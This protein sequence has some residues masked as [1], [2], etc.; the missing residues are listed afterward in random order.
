MVFC[1][2]YAPAPL[3]LNRAVARH[4]ASCQVDIKGHRLCL[5]GL[6]LKSASDR[7]NPSS[8]RPISVGAAGIPL[9][10]AGPSGG[11]SSEAVA[12]RNCNLW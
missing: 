1:G 2:G 8:P 3:H 9:G 10:G 6:G 12:A 5:E 11:L 4:L 7:D